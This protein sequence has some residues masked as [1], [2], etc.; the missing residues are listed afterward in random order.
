MRKSSSGLGLALLTTA[1]LAT[2]ACDARLGRTSAPIDAAQSQSTE[3]STDTRKKAEATRAGSPWDFQAKSIEHPSILQAKNRTVTAYVE[4]PTTSVALRSNPSAKVQIGWRSVGD[5]HSMHPVNEVHRTTSVHNR[6]EHH[7][8]HSKEWFVNDVRGL[9]HGIDLARRPDGHNKQSWLRLDF[10]VNTTLEGAITEDEKSATWTS[11]NGRVLRYQDLRAWDANNQKLATKMVLSKNN[12]GHLLQ[13]RID[14]R[15]AVYPITIDPTFTEDATMTHPGGELG[16][17]F[18]CSVALTSDLMVVGACMDDASAQITSSGAAYLYGR[19]Q[20]GP[21][22]WGLLKKITAS[23]ATAGTYFGRAVAIMADT[24]VIADPSRPLPTGTMGVGAL[25]VYQKDLGGVD[26]WGELTIILGSDATN[27]R[28]LG[29]AVAID[30]ETQDGS[31][32]DGDGRVDECTVI[33]AAAYH[34][35]PGVWV[36]DRDQGGTNSFGETTKMTSTEYNFG[37]GLDVK[38]PRLAIGNPNA[39]NGAGNVEIHELQGASWILAHNVQTTGGL[40]GDFGYSLRLVPGHASFPDT[41]LIGAPYQNQGQ[42]ALYVFEWGID[43]ASGQGSFLETNTIVTSD[44]TTGDQFGSAIAAAEGYAVVGA[45]QKDFLGAAYVFKQGNGW[46]EDSKLVYSAAQTG[47][48]GFAASLAIN[49][50][51]DGGLIAVSDG[52]QNQYSGAAHRFGIPNDSPVANPQ[53]V[54]TAEDTPS[55]AISLTGTDADGD[56]LTF[57]ITRLPNNGTFLS[58]NTNGSVTYQPNPDFHG[59]DSFEFVATDALQA[60]SPPAVVTIDVTAVNDAPVASGDAHT[61]GEDNTFVIDAA[62][63]VLANDTDIDSSASALTAQLVTDVSHGTLTLD[64]DGSFTYVPTPDFFGTDSFTYRAADDEPLTSNLATVTLTVISVNDAPVATADAHTTGEDNTLV[65]DAANGVL[66]NDTDI[67]SS[68]SALTAQLVTDVSHGTLTLNSDGSFTY[69]PTPDFFGTD[70]FTYRAADDEPLTSN[71]ATVTLTVISVNDAPVVT[72]DAHNIGEDAT[73]VID[74]ATGVLAN[75]TDID[76]PSSTL[77]ANLD[78]DVSNGALTLAADGSF[79]YVPAPDF[80]GTDQFTYYAA[81]DEPLASNT[82]TVTLTVTPDNDAPVAVADAH[83]IAEDGTLVI[84][85]ANGVLSND[86]DIDSPSSTLTANLDTDVSNGALTLAADGSFTYVP[87]PDFFGTDQFT[88]T[89]SDDEPLSSNATTVTLTIT[90]ENDRPATTDQSLNTS[91]NNALSVVLTGSDVDG[92]PLTYELKSFPMNGALTGM[93]ANLTYTPN[94]GFTGTDSFEFVARD[95]VLASNLSTITITVTPGD[96]TPQADSQTVSL[97]EDGTLDIAL[98][99]SDPDGDPITFRVVDGPLHGA[100]TGTPPQLIYTPD[101]DYFGPDSFTFTTDDGTFTSAPATVSITVRSVEDIPQTEPNQ[102]VTATSDRE[103]RFTVSATDGDG[104]FL[105][106]K[107]TTLPNF[108]TVEIDTG[109]INTSS[110]DVTFVYTPNMGFVG[111]DSFAYT[112]EDTQGNPSMET[113][114][115]VNVEPPDP[116]ETI[117]CGMDEQCQNGV[118]FLVCDSD[119]DCTVPGHLCYNQLCKDDPCEEVACPTS[120]TCYQATCFEACTTGADC[121]D[122]GHFCWDSIICSAD[123]CQTIVC[124]TTQSCFGGACFD[125]CTGGIDCSDAADLCYDDNYCA[126]DLCDSVMCPADQA[127]HGGAC[128]DTCTTGADC[129]DPGAFC[130]DARYCA[131]DACQNV[132]CPSGQACHGGACFETCTDSMDCSDPS[133]LCYGTI[134][135]AD[136]CDVM[137]CPVGDT[138]YAGTCFES[139]DDSMDCTDPGALCYDSLCQ[140]ERCQGVL[141]PS[142]QSCYSGACFESCSAGV[143]CSDPAAFCYDTVCSADLCESITCA[144]GQTCY[145]GACFETCESAEDCSNPAD[146]CFGEICTQDP[147]NVV[148][149]P[150]DQTCYAGGCFENCMGAEDCAQADHIC[151]DER[152]TASPCENVLCPNPQACYNGTCFESC[153]TDGECTDAADLC[154]DSRCATDA[155]EGVTCPEEQI[156]YAGSCFESCASSDDCSDPGALCYGARCMTDPCEG[157]TCSADQV[158]YG[159]S[160]FE[161]CED[162]SCEAGKLCID[163]RCAT[164]ACEDVLCPVGLVCSSGDCKVPEKAT[165]GCGGCSSADGQIDGTLFFLVGLLGWLARRRRIGAEKV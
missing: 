20:G 161:A 124:G 106:F 65:V 139:C 111:Q 153:E 51:S 103:T 2:S 32:T 141:C 53:G 74:A 76:S 146:Q 102:M 86:N 151:F 116:C 72:A 39:A 22:N 162:G 104:D 33:A 18:G 36:F 125:S 52:R 55:F 140:T 101:T 54:N 81:D 110:T 70:T 19:D 152:C 97:D 3:P 1:I 61:T 27:Y 136:P 31:D 12:R 78:T 107:I 21:G 67:D 126:V 108:G 48:G 164:D 8:T 57:A 94:M 84:N 160:C 137:Y 68:A 138:C 133:A 25:Y 105:T 30:C 92:D 165:N 42:G 127:C 62:T 9:E 132:L 6:V 37:W 79:T 123:P 114:V 50:P 149:C 130:Y 73:L 46:A 135:A 121:S 5:D 71:L 35:T 58:T 93:G 64:S 59:Q 23:D 147:C 91:E 24:L 150:N 109:G 98:T 145:G 4:G 163:A 60:T 44:G 43:P 38:G 154:Y 83:S 10:D 90:P 142:G 16:K 158:C 118:C 119:A 80:F 15:T 112:A 75:D 40:G 129:S 45:P 49:G 122:P 69:V 100:L 17:E 148:V 77:T 29:D 156:C 144:G 66:A 13:W 28:G 7:R 96:H 115:T 117:T 159:G 34:T 113:T 82:V 63:G 157:V 99:G 131:T 128:F 85:Q 56:P 88:Y 89:A 87:A 134:C 155:C 11:P 120:Q 47:E 95:G 41:L 143:D 26:N 14:D